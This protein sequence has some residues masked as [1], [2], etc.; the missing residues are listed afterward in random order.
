MHGAFVLRNDSWS[1]HVY[2]YRYIH[3][4]I[5][6]ECVV[7]IVVII[8]CFLIVLE[9]DYSKFNVG[10]GLHCVWI[11]NSIQ[12]ISIADSLNGWQLC[13]KFGMVGAVE[14]CAASTWTRRGVLRYWHT[15]TVGGWAI[16]AA[17]FYCPLPCGQS[18][19]TTNMHLGGIHG[20]S[21]WYRNQL[22]IF[23]DCYNLHCVFS[24]LSCY[25]TSSLSCV[26]Y[27]CVDSRSGVAVLY[28]IF[29]SCDTKTS[30]NPTSL[31]RS[32]VCEV[33]AYSMN[34]AIRAW[35]KPVWGSDTPTLQRILCGYQVDM[36]TLLLHFTSPSWKIG[37]FMLQQSSI[38]QI[39]PSFFNFCCHPWN[40][41][42]HP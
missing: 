23:I 5:W 41:C 20:I 17:M 42:R 39:L 13:L 16:P 18:D 4:Y 9:C 19:K 33:A 26:F 37:A 21:N 14:E 32:I 10:G 24:K 15:S 12:M 38:F 2:I 28:S 6:M 40:A 1:L 30:G 8:S 3:A 31:V 35:T 11:E 22:W 34:Q 25:T 29:H 36:L 7:V 27:V